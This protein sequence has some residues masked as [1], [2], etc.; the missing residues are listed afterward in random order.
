MSQTSSPSSFVLQVRPG[1][2]ITTLP[3]K[4]RAQVSGQVGGTG[5]TTRKQTSVRSLSLFQNSLGL[6]AVRAYCWEMLERSLLHGLCPHLV[7]QHLQD[8]GPVLH[9]AAEIRLQVAVVHLHTVLGE[10]IALRHFCIRE[11][12]PRP[13]AGHGTNPRS[14]FAMHLGASV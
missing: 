5:E 11:V 1:V 10:R 13:A 9:L 6:S 12:S 3:E 8:A 14:R 4:V 2:S 7:Q